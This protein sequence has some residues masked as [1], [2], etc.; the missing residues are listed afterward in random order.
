MAADLLQC[1][2]PFIL[3]LEATTAKELE[4]PKD[5]IQVHL[6]SDY[7]C[8]PKDFLGLAPMSILCARI[9]SV[10]NPGV[11]DLD[12]PLG[13]GGGGSAIGGT[14]AAGTASKIRFLFREF[15]SELLQ[16][17]TESTFQVGQGA[18][19]TILLD[20][21][22]YKRAKATAA[23]TAEEFYLDR[24]RLPSGGGQGFAKKEEEV[25][26]LYNRHC[27]RLLDQFV[28]TQMLSHFLSE[29]GWE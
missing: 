11:E 29:G 22:L 21:H 9:S 19:A 20:E 3:G 13:G 1:P 16:G 10:L 18:T 6:D 4:L 15:V 12:C 24:R 5:A 14:S 23:K 25:G 2:T 28:K 7:L 27:D 17:A 26:P 8:V